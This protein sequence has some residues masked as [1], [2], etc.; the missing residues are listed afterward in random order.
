MKAISVLF[1]IL[2]LT[3]ACADRGAY[4][5]PLERK[6]SWYSYLNGD[7]LR[8][9]CALGQPD[10]ARLIYNAIHTE[11]IRTYDLFI[12]SED[13]SQYVLESRVLGPANLSRLA[14]GILGPWLGDTATTR[15]RIE[16]KELLWAVMEN[17]GVFSGGK[18]GL[19]LIS[20]KFFWLAAACRDGQFYY[21]AY[22]WPSA[23]FDA[24]QFDDLL[25]AWDMTG[26]PVNPPRFATMFDIYGDASPIRK[27]GAYYHVTVDENGL[28]GF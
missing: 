5:N 23:E 22:A 11:Q 8:E 6:L 18:D 19:Y 13:P 2:C 25:F 10:S 4:V 24:L 9:S 16:D 14:R 12:S 27:T 7:T 1:S 3:A 28:R 20:E 21:N 26:V 17:G 15:I